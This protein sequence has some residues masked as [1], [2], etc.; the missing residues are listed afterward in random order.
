MSEVNVEDP[1]V[2]TLRRLLCD[3]YPSE[4][5]RMAMLD[6]GDAFERW[7]Q[8]AEASINTSDYAAVV[9]RVRWLEEPA[10]VDDE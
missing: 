8:T 1:A 9:A 5:K 2:E 7:A 6:N 4:D 3:A 10:S